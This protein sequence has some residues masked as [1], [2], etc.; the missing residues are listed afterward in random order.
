MK[1]YALV[2]S[3]GTGKSHRSALLAYRLGIKYIIDD[4]L[5]IKGNQVL[6]GRSA[7]REKTRMAATKVAVFLDHE[8][9]S[10]VRNKIKELLPDRILVIG[11]S[12]RMIEQ[13]VQRLELPIPEEIVRIEEIAGPSE[14]SKALGIREK[15]NRHAIPIPTFAIEKDFPGYILDPIK[16]FFLGKS[17]SSPPQALE[18]SV[19]RPLYSSLGN[20]FLSEHAIEQIAV[21]VAQ[22]VEGV[23][24]AYKTSIVTTVNGMVINMEVVLQFKRAYLPDII[25]QVQDEVKSK[26]V[27][28]TG[29]QVARINVT[30]KRLAPLAAAKI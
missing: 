12:E 3:S 16:A 22:Q 2:G 23:H 29:F 6:A 28:L 27:S 24:R 10:Q 1:T 13:I 21:H 7:K 15:E 11:I 8:H 19:V 25:R 30:A 9:A 5:L 14:I 17:H 4:G 26:I 20:Y 18:Y